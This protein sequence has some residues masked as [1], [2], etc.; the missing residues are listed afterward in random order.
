[1][2]NEIRELGLVSKYDDNR[3][4]LEIDTRQSK[5]FPSNNR[6][7]T[8]SI[9]PDVFLNGLKKESTL[10]LLNHQPTQVVS[11]KFE[12]RATETGVEIEVELDEKNVFS[13][14]VQSY[15]KNG[16]PLSVSFGFRCKEE[17]MEN[18]HREIL[19]LEIGEVSILTVPSQYFSSTRSLDNPISI[20]ELKQMIDESV[21][22]ALEPK[23]EVIVEE[24]KVD[25]P[26]EKEEPKVAE[27]NPTSVNVKLDASDFKEM[28]DTFLHDVKEAFPK[29]VEPVQVQVKE[30]VKPQIDDENVIDADAKNKLLEKLN[31]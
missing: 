10:I 28:F 26:V 3:I 9:S 29:Q 19:D 4:T 15:R 5:R 18:K 14:T 20:E 27:F 1:M 2:N 6:F 12:A 31:F 22:K 24:V 11:N 21:A 17:R 8:E 23:Q 25:T 13:T 7:L 16:V 30:E